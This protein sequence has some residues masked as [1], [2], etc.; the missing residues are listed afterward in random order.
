MAESSAPPQGGRRRSTRVETSAANAEPT[1]D[2]DDFARM[3][4]LEDD[5]QRKQQLIVADS[6]ATRARSPL[7]VGKYNQVCV[8]LHLNSTLLSTALTRLTQCAFLA[9]KQWML[10]DANRQTGEIVRAE[11]AAL[12]RRREQS[13][14]AYHEARQKKTAVGRGQQ[15]LTAGSVREYRGALAKT[16]EAGRAELMHLRAIAI[17]QKKEWAAHGARNAAVHGLE[18]KKRVLEARA[19]RFQTRRNAA[20]QT[21]QEMAAR[22]ASAR[23]LA[24]QGARERLERLERVREE[25]PTIE[26]V[27]AAREIFAKQKRESAAAVRNSVKDWEA[28][29]RKGDSQLLAKATANRSVVMA[30]RA[31]AATNRAGVKEARTRL[32]QDIRNAL[33][34]MESGRR[35]QL[36]VSR[37]QT[38]AHHKD[39]YDRRF[40]NSEAATRVDESEYGALVHNTR[41]PAGR[42]STL[43][44]ASVASDSPVIG[45]PSPIP[46]Q[47]VP[48]AW[49]DGSNGNRFSGYKAPAS[50][51]AASKSEPIAISDAEVSG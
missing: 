4:E 49:G 17:R 45:L 38:E 6:N 41:S 44:A 39:L 8:L 28:E 42:S 11:E 2:P 14:I 30:T 26:D 47:S 18:Q 12:Q 37:Q 51:V 25:I 19:E 40:V 15:E 46:E 24:G 29:R 31:Q 36:E 22:K 27:A 33:V 43:S 32:A 3:L 13:T 48:V 34:Q 10:I 23:V 1:V 20:L 50:R 9:L 21:K 7:S 16:G 35:A 5:A